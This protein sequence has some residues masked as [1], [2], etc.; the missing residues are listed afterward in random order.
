MCSGPLHSCSDYN[1]QSVVVHAKSTE[2]SDTYHVQV[3]IAYPIN[4]FTLGC[5]ELA[6]MTPAALCMSVFL[7]TASRI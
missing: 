1:K 5:V 7:E 4:K 3:S 6:H 2:G